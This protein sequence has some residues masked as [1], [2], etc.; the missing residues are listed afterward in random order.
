MNEERMVQIHVDREVEIEEHMKCGANNK[1][2]V[3]D[4]TRKSVADLQ[5]ASS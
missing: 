4:M 5:F 3:D 1:A 2:L